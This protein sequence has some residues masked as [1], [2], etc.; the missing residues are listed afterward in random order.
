[1]TLNA[2]R[3]MTKLMK[4]EKF[5]ELKKSKKPKVFWQLNFGHLFLSDFGKIQK[6]L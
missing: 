3:M 6:T 5:E 2:G 1:M 4:N